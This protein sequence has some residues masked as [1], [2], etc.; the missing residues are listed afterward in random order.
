[1]IHAARDGGVVVAGDG[2]LRDVTHE[3]GALVRRPAVA[4]R[5]TQAVVDVDV[6]LPIRLEDGRERLEIRMDVA[7]DTDPH[8]TTRLG[9]LAS[10][11]KR[12]TQVIS[13]YAARG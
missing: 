4:D 10:Q 12:F 1:V 3:I 6:L 8:G 5:V 11:R 2:R 13:S 9:G 7:E